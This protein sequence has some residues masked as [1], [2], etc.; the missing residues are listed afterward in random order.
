[1]ARI[2]PRDFLNPA[3]ALRQAFTHSRPSRRRSQ[4]CCSSLLG[5][6][7]GSSKHAV[8]FAVDPLG[9]QDVFLD[10]SH[11]RLQD[12]VEFLNPFE[13]LFRFSDVG[14][15]EVELRSTLRIRL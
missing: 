6:A 8:D 2:S 4:F 3:A 1:M 14:A 13:N 15:G 5:G 10:D 12:P 9:I 11:P 7:G